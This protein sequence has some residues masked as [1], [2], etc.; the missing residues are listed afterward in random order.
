MFQIPKMLEAWQIS[1]AHLFDSDFKDIELN[2]KYTAES[3]SVLLIDH[4]LELDNF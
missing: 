3:Y 4:T 2:K 1:I